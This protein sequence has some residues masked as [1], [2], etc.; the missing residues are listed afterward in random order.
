[1][2]TVDLDENP[3]NPF[4]EIVLDKTPGTDIIIPARLDASLFLSGK[5][6]TPGIVDI[7]LRGI[8]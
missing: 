2:L 6:E 1:M 8:R 5:H 3:V 7:H 4:I